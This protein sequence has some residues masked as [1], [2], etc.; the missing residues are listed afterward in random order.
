MIDDQLREGEGQRLVRRLDE[1]IAHARFAAALDAIDEYESAGAVPAAV[2]TA[3]LLARCRSLLGLGRWKEVSDVAERK[4][5]ELYALRP[6]EKK[7]LLE[8]HLAAGRAA[9]RVG[10]PGRAEEHFRAAYHIS[11]W[12]LEDVGAMLRA[13]NLLGLSF[14]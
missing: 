3:I 4:L 8:F 7:A 10:R 6:D 1:L 13:R 14:L 2:E 12:D 5:E 11:R 9:W